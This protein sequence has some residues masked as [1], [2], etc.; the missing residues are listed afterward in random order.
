MEIE[1]SPMLLD[2]APEPVTAGIFIA[3]ILL[4]IAFVVLLLGG[5]V[6]FLWYRK[7]SMRGV[8]MTFPENVPLAGATPSQPSNPNQP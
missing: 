2:V 4:V 5:L 6:A 8:E 3:V 7:R 1:N